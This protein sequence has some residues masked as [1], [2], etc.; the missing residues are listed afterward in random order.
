MNT[1][2]KVY[3]KSIAAIVFAVVLILIAIFHCRPY[4]EKNTFIVKGKAEDV[5]TENP[6]GAG[7]PDF[8][9]FTLGGRKYYYMNIGGNR[10]S[11]KAL[12]SSIEEADEVILHCTDQP[13]L[14]HPLTVGDCTQAVKVETAVAQTDWKEHNKR[15]IGLRVLCFAAAVLL[16]GIALLIIKL[17]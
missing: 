7:S 17:K 2:L 10:E 12:K 11:T 15:Q 4:N 1:S 13:F 5:F 16:L 9:F 8:L 14:L 3:V 6:G